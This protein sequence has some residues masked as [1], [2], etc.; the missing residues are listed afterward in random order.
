MKQILLF[1]SILS[2]TCVN[3]QNHTGAYPNYNNTNRTVIILEERKQSL[4]DVIMEQERLNLQRNE[5]RMRNEYNRSIRKENRNNAKEGKRLAKIIDNEL[6]L[7]KNLLSE[8]IDN[9]RLNST[10]VGLDSK[11]LLDSRN[12]YRDIAFGTHKYDIRNLEQTNHGYYLYKSPNSRDYNISD[13]IFNNIVFNFDRDNKLNV[14]SLFKNYLVYQSPGVMDI[15]LYDLKQL[16][17]G[18]RKQL[19]RE[20]FFKKTD[21]SNVFVWNS[22]D[23]MVMIEANINENAFIEDEYG[24]KIVPY[25]TLS[26]SYYKNSNLEQG[27]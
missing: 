7:N 15:G 6:E 25:Y 23:V 10:G 4:A 18:A 8:V 21:N 20:S 14:I 9:L 3:A 26:V 11:H 22:T 24:N 5:Q 2:F 12:G 19:G 27:I 13:I 16:I 17:E 1:L